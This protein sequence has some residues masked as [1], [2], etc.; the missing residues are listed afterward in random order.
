MSNNM[1]AIPHER[2]R[3]VEY[4]TD[5]EMHPVIR[6][7]AKER[8]I[9]FEEMRML[10]LDKGYGCMASPQEGGFGIREREGAPMKEYRFF[11]AR[12]KLEGRMQ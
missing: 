12:A 5:I 10:L 11:E 1:H 6:A 7:Q 4:V 9:V 3:L 8:A 2:Y